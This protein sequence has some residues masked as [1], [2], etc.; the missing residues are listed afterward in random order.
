MQVSAG[1]IG[2]IIDAIR[3][4]LD[5]WLGIPRRTTKEGRIVLIYRMSSESQP[6]VPMRL[7]ARRWRASRRWPIVGRPFH[8]GSGLA[9]S[10]LPLPC[11]LGYR[12]PS[13]TAFVAVALLACDSLGEF[14]VGRLGDLEVMRVVQC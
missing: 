13:G 2:S 11:S 10:R 7:K 12:S 8:P 4:A 9:Y 6:P 1:P 14:A 5:P 3:R